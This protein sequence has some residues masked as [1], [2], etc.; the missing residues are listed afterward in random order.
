[1]A[2][3]LAN[4]SPARPSRV[5][6]S[7]SIRGPK[8][9][10]AQMIENRR[11]S[12]VIPAGRQRY[13]ELLIP[14]LLREQGWDELQIWVNTTVRGDLDYLE[15][16]LSL[17]Q[18][19]RLVRLPGGLVPDGWN[20]IHHFFVNCVEPDTVYIRVDDDIV[21]IEPGAIEGLARF[22]ISHE[23]P[24]LVFPV[25]INNAIITHVLQVLGRI[26][27]SKY[28]RAQC[29]DPVGWKNPQV[30]ERIHRIFLD[31]LKDDQIARFKFPS[32]LIALSRMSINCISWLGSEF[33]KFGGILGSP[34]EEEWLS[35]I[36]PTQLGRVN[37]IYGGSIMAH[38]AFYTQRDHLD[39]TDILE[40]Y[41]AV[42]SA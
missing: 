42:V 3:P 17:D 36:R 4:R 21:Y 33:A 30:A 24:F 34:D 40:R 20:T 16:L 29:M 19:I 38:F 15:Q 22:R 1:M 13:M 12:I 9:L 37:A 10:A 31:A 8:R 27:L 41:R 7:R 6:V 25:I 14:Q 26:K 5:I 23:N 18:R 28:V 32:R 35:V 11:I 39:K 2:G